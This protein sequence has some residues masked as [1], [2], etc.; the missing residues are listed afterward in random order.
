M[1]RISTTPTSPIGRDTQNR[2]LVESAAMDQTPLTRARKHLM[3][4]KLFIGMFL[5]AIAGIA[6]GDYLFNHSGAQEAPKKAEPDKKNTQCNQFDSLND[7]LEAKK[8]AAD[9]QRP[10]H[11]P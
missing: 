9:N 4:K 2:S 7:G 8:D 10:V 1:R 5:V 6:A 3:R 11:F